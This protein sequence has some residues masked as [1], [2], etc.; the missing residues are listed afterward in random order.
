MQAR[1]L[2]VADALVKALEQRGYT[3]ISGKQST[4]VDILGI[5]VSFAFFE[6]AKRTPYVPNEAEKKKVARDE[7]VWMN[8]PGVLRHFPGLAIEPQPE[9]LPPPKGHS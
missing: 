5:Q 9:R 6:S 8:R 4:H 7:S 2:R 1:A 3:V